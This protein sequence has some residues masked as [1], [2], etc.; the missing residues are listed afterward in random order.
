[1]DADVKQAQR[2]SETPNG[3]DVE[4]C[5]DE[6]PEKCQRKSND[7]RDDPVCPQ[8]DGGEEQVSQTPDELEALGRVR[9]SK[10]VLERQVD[11]VVDV[12]IV[13]V[14]DVEADGEAVEVL[15]A[16]D[17]A[18]WLALLG[19]LLLLLLLLLV[20]LVVVGGGVVLVLVLLVLSSLGLHLDLLLLLRGFSLAFLLF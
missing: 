6:G 3:A 12:L 7:G 13:S 9:L 11:L 17:G 1:M 18:A 10:N 14:D 8:S 2:R 16:V 5:E 20:F 15:G 4:E 19:L